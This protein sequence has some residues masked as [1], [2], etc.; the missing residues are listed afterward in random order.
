MA[1]SIRSYRKYGT[2]EETAEIDTFS[3]PLAFHRVL[4]Q[5]LMESIAASN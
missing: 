1:R 3:E 4:Q 2:S 5:R